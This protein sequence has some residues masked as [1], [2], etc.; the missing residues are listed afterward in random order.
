[1]PSFIS[2]IYTMLAVGIGWVFFMSD[3]IGEA[4]TYLRTCFFLGGYPVF[5][6]STLFFLR[7]ST[8][9]MIISIICSTETP[10][11][12]M[13]RLKEKIPAVWIIV[14]FAMLILSTAYLLYSSYNPFLYFRF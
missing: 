10:E 1:M 13:Q 2:H 7:T 4:L 8:I 3:S 5:N 9:L 12:A 6:T 14:I 11:K